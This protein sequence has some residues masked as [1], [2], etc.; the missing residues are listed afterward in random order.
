MSIGPSR[1]LVGR[2]VGDEVKGGRAGNESGGI[3]DSHLSIENVLQAII[4]RRE[5]DEH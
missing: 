1:S 2:T 3:P 4:A 5:A